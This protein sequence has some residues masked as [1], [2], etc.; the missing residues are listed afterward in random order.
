[1]SPYEQKSD[2]QHERNQ[3]NVNFSTSRRLSDDEKEKNIYN[4]NS[5]EIT[6]ENEW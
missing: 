6:Y 2:I 3:E 5:I 4:L 1:M